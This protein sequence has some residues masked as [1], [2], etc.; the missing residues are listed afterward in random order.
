MAE[1]KK[2]GAHLD[3]LD[4]LRALLA[5]YVVQRHAEVYFW[6]V[7]ESQ[8]AKK[9]SLWSP[10][11]YAHFAVDIFIVISG[12]CLFLPVVRAGV[13]LR[14]GALPFF[15]RRARRILPPYYAALVASLLGLWITGETAQ[16]TGPNFSRVWQHVLLVHDALS[17][18]SPNSAL[19][20]IAV[21]CHIYLL[22]P[23]L[24]LSW[25]RLGPA[26][27]LAWSAVVAAVLYVGLL[28]TTY[29]VI[30]PQ[31]LLLFGFGMGAAAIFSSPRW[32]DLQR[33]PWGI[34][35]AVL[36][37][38]M[39]AVR[40][41]APPRLV[42]QYLF[43]QDVLVGLGAAALLLAAAR[44]GPVSTVLSVR[45]LVRIGHFSYSIYLIHIP[46]LEVIAYFTGW[47]LSKVGGVQKPV[48]L[49]AL[50]AVATAFAYLFYLAFERP[51]VPAARPA[52]P[53]PEAAGAA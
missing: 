38:G 15:K 4:G 22:F 52:A 44:P 19:W 5:L 37:P 20:S 39:M 28:S 31:Y 25:R 42:D 6:R 18:F 41:V 45:P 29:R 7:M 13:T 17:P 24:V 48:E 21:E 1:A 3:F 14:G 51:F 9:L 2:P 30:T 10:L 16:F 53:A 40:Y 32:P 33:V 49:L 12:F 36:I 27:T 35:A 23:L 26:G 46:I 34:A 50:V 8:M 43:V 47:N 11:R